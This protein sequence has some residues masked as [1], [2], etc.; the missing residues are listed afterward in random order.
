MSFH[1]PSC[2]WN[3][4]PYFWHSCFISTQL[5]AFW[6]N[7]FK[8]TSQKQCHFTLVSWIF[9][10]YFV[11]FQT[12][13]ETS[14]EESPALLPWLSA[15]CC[16]LPTSHPAPPRLFLL[17]EY[18]KASPLCHIL[19]HVNTSVK[20]QLYRTKI[21]RTDS[22]SKKKGISTSYQHLG[23]SNPHLTLILKKKK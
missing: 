16:F 12:H 11:M 8:S 2:S 19:S 4:Y 1:A 15:F 13:P 22:V 7:C 18:F 9:K 20:Y 10:L 21:L 5:P 17:L 3:H 6:L 14:T 23:H